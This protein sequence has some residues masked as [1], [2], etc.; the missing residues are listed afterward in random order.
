[1]T[2]LIENAVEHFKG[3]E[4]RKMEVPEWDVT[5]YAKNLTLDDKAKMLRRADSDN[6]DYLIYALIFGLADDQGEPVFTIEDRL[7]L[8]GRADPDIVTRLATFVLTADSESEEDREKN[9]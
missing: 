1:M 6:T 9:S 3:K 4:L 5:V 2:K 8:R 7:A